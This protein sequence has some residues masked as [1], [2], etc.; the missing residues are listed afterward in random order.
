[1]GKS[2]HERKTIFICAFAILSI[3]IGRILIY[4]RAIIFFCAAISLQ[5]LFPVAIFTST[6]VYWKELAWNYWEQLPPTTTIDQDVM[7][8]S[9]VTPIPILN[10][11]EFA[12]CSRSRNSKSHCEISFESG[13]SILSSLDLSQPLLIT[14]AVNP[15][16][17]DRKLSIEGMMHPPLKD[18][19]VHYFSDARKG[20]LSP[21]R[22][23]LLG[24][25][26]YN[27]T[28]NGD[29]YAKI[30]SQIPM[31]SYPELI[32]EITIPLFTTL[33]GDRFKPSDLDPFLG[34]KALTT[35]PIFLAGG[36][37]TQDEGH[38][39]TDLHSEPIGNIAVQLEGE[40]RWLLVDP[41][42]TSLLRPTVAA[43]GRAFF[44]SA[45][46]PSELPE[47]LRSLPHYEVVTKPGDALWIPTWF[48]HRV[49][50]ENDSASFGASLF[51]FRPLE[52]IRN[53]PLFGAL[54][55]PNL[56]KELAG[57]KFQ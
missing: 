42:Y 4:D 21:D 54:I 28:S 40:K 35:V 30:G 29:C 47:I 34:L 44:H 16:S 53:N 1:M 12:E 48:W 50:Y 3:I 38:A 32:K 5:S 2:N 33:F 43:D 57:F 7:K 41:I 27:I 10:A 31:H 52:Y 26:V 9:A 14:N 11:S 20:L 36:E 15:S 45:Y 55:I 25:I 23:A 51:H 37:A 39:R 19:S 24:D 8:E 56:L 46:D 6:H 13:E 49:D 22:T 18:L 17:T